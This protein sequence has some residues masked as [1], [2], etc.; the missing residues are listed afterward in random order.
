MRLAAAGLALA[1]LAATVCAGEEDDP[2]L[3]VAWMTGSFSSAAQ[4][5]ADTSYLDIRLEVVPVWTD[6]A[7]GHWLYVEQAVA[8]HI[9]RPYRQRVYHVTAG[10]SGEI[11]SAV[12][13]IP[14]PLRFAGAWR[15]PA[16]LAALAPDSL[17]LREGCTVVLRRTER[18]LFEGG[19]AG[20]GCASSLAG[21]AYATSLVELSPDR[22]TS[23]D[24]GF[25]REGNQVWGAVDGPYVFDRTAGDSED[26]RPAGTRG[27]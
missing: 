14:D 24:R 27:P 6:R 3:G 26:S 13:T 15:E 7:D 23:W 10:D 4:A 2:S 25:D 19:T 1:A 9:E 5:A 22:L 16:P 18:D 20:S 12:L 21:A 17:D 8:D 11:T